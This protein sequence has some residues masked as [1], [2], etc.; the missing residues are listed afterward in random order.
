MNVR[1]HVASFAGAA[2]LCALAL[3]SKKPT[4]AEM[5]KEKADVRKDYDDYVTKMGAAYTSL[6]ALDKRSLPEKRCN[7]P[8]IVAK[9]PE[10]EKTKEGTLGGIQRVY[11]GFLA[12]FAK[13]SDKTAWTKDAGPWAFVTDTGFSGHFADHV[14]TRQQYGITDTVRR[15]R[16]ELAPRRYV[17]VIW[18]TNEADNHAPVVDAKQE[19]FVGGNFDGWLFL[20]DIVGGAVE[21]QGRM[22][23]TSS[24]TVTAR[25]GG[26]GI[27][28]LA[29]KDLKTAVK[30]DFEDAFEAAM[31]RILGDRIRFS[32]MG[33]ILK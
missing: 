27:G 24:D 14:D 30:D 17:I 13:P 6:A 32:S 22:T 3:G 16:E 33:S 7:V 4:D 28:R 18:P 31:K 15:I 20:Y 19:G 26:R 8:A 9:V 5:A 11:S 23:V 25:T 21:C 29:N 12:R 10:V 2:L 1:L